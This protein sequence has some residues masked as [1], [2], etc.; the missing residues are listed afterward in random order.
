MSSQYCW[1]I[2]SWT[3]ADVEAVGRGTGRLDDRGGEGGDNNKGCDDDEARGNSASPSVGVAD[4]SAS[5]YLSDLPSLVLALFKL[6]VDVS[7]V[8][9]LG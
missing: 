8:T 1:R 7:C 5:S 6:H 3:E 9:D 2:G 4:E